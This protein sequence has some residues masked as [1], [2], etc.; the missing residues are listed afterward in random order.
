MS[1]SALIGID[2][3]KHTFHLHGQDKSGRE[4]FPKN[5]HGRT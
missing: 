3:G 2:L 5:V 1:E 4:V